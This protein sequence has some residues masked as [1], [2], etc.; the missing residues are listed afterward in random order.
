MNAVPNQELH[1]ELDESVE[2][3]RIMNCPW[4]ITVESCTPLSARPSS[5]SI[6]DKVEP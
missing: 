1:D 6:P 4:P 2:S 3:P 5:E